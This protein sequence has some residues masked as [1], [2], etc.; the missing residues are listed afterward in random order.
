MSQSLKQK[1]IN[2]ERRRQYAYSNKASEILPPK[3]IKQTAVAQSVNHMV[4]EESKFSPNVGF[5]NPK[6]R[7]LIPSP[8]DIKRQ[9]LMP[10][11]SNTMTDAVIKK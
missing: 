5:D 8:T 4:K 3:P 10:V 6:H 1:P 7:I 2:D 9:M 11:T